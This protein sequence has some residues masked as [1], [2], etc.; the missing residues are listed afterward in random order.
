MLVEGGFPE[1]SFSL[2]TLRIKDTKVFEVLASTKEGKIASIAEH[3][4]RFP[5]RRFVL[6]G[7]TGEFD[8]EVYG[9]I[10]RRFDDRIVYIAIRNVTGDDPGSARYAAAFADVDAPWE[11]FTDPAA[12]RGPPARQG[13]T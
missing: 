10:A 6:V 13:P 3:V 11:L 7:D 8:P 12:L 4:Q 9:E 1:A 2:K 5:A